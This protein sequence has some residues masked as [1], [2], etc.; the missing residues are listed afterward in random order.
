MA[1][2][3]DKK[4]IGA[5]LLSLVLTLSL[6]LP[7]L[8]T[9]QTTRAEDS[10]VYAVVLMPS[11]DKELT[12]KGEV[13]RVF[14][15]SGLYFLVGCS[16]TQLTALQDDGYVITDNCTGSQDECLAQL[17]ETLRSV[18]ILQTAGS[19]GGPDNFGYEFTDSTEGN[20]CY[21]WI[22]I[23]KTGRNTGINCDD[24]GVTVP[25]GFNFNFYGN[26]YNAVTI[27]SN[28][29]L[30]FG[31]E[32]YYFSNYC[33]PD[34]DT[35]NNIIC[36][37]WDDLYSSCSGSAIYYDTRLAGT[38]NAFIVE[39]VGNQFCC[40][41]PQP[42]RLTF[43][44]VL[45]QKSGN[46]LFQYLDMTGPGRV[47]GS[48]ATIGIENSDGTDGLQYSCDS[49][50]IS[51]SLAILFYL[52][53]LEHNFN[54]LNYTPTAPK[55]K[56]SP[57]MPGNITPPQ[58]SLQYLNITPK[59]TSASQPV[60][61]STNVVNTGDQAGNYN[62]VLKINGQ[63]EESRMVSVGP[64]TSQ[65]VKFTVARSQP[66]TYSVDVGVQQGSFIVLGNEKYGGTPVNASLIVILAFGV[67]AVIIVLMIVLRRPA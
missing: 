14:D 62:V 9:P 47:D 28:G 60:T 23:T 31:G 56:V 35:P 22:D 64:L 58:I 29:Y 20:I 45:Y 21:S 16:E 48:S 25:I 41:C 39:W 51:N 12:I 38:D 6:L 8:L 44:A 50:A 18:P 36:P 3:M 32:P 52:P 4:V 53:P 24:C 33:I 66:G 43:E 5:V 67:V 30:T 59:Q 26:N 7:A 63:T 37:F 61:I 65:P 49:P 34:T 2:T 42:W 13:E 11:P 40:G 54:C 46:I 55:P 57:S 17:Y 27:S 15:S 10:E 19:Q 1:A